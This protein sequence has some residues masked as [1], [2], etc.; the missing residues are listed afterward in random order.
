MTTLTAQ[1][2]LL[3]GN[4]SGAGSADLRD[5]EDMEFLYKWSNAGKSINKD[6]ALEGAEEL[7]K[8]ELYYINA[9]S[10]ALRNGKPEL[11]L[12][13]GGFNVKAVRALATKLKELHEKQTLEK[14]M[15][16]AV[17]K[18]QEQGKTGKSDDQYKHIWNGDSANTE[19][20]A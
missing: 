5:E 7:Y 2:V 13:F 9:A 8:A 19:Y 3:S 15:K 11:R 20:F 16:D 6:S 12:A 14:Q 17:E 4:I 10:R 18:A 1:N